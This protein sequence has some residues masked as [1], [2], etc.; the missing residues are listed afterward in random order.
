MAMTDA[1][2]GAYPFNVD[3][4]MLT[5]DARPKLDKIYPRLSQGIQLRGSPYATLTAISKDNIEDCDELDES[6]RNL[7]YQVTT[8]QKMSRNIRKNH[9]MAMGY[10]PTDGPRLLSTTETMADIFMLGLKEID[11]SFKNIMLLQSQAQ[12]DSLDT[13]NRQTAVP[14]WRSTP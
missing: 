3:L 11:K 7:R 13:V 9:P 1:K 2:Q 12:A 8:A 10:S 6:K 14:D 4:Q 5:H